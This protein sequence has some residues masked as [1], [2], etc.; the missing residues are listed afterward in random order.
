MPNK[1]YFPGNAHQ[2]MHGDAHYP[3]AKATIDEVMDVLA[4]G[5]EDQ[6]GLNRAQWLQLLKERYA[7]DLIVWIARHYWFD[8]LKEPVRWLE[9]EIKHQL[10]E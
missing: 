2:Q 7:D 10:D 4:H 1:F 3:G 5:G 8:E 6:D 9:K